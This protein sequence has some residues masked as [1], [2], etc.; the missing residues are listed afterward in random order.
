MEIEVILSRDHL[1][2]GELNAVRQKG[3]IVAN[4]SPKLFSKPRIF[5][6]GCSKLIQQSQPVTT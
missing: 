3:V 6:R 4:G 2:S 5:V 1:V